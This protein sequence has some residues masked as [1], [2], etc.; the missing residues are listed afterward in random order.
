MFIWENDNLSI[1]IDKIVKTTTLE[2]NSSGLM[3]SYVTVHLNEA[4]LE[5]L[6][7]ALNEAKGNLKA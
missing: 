7:N 5:Q 3:A 6:I 1:R 4:E 2:A